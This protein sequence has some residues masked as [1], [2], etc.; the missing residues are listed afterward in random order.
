[1]RRSVALREARR[2]GVPPIRYDDDLPVSAKRDEIASAIRDHQVVIICGE[3]GSGKS[4]QLPKICLELGRGIDGLI[5]HTQPRRI[6]ARSVAARIAEELGSPLGR[7]VGFK[8]RFAEAL[9]P[10][11]YIKLMT[12]GILLAETQGDAFLDQ[13]DTII[14]DEAHE[15]SLNIDFLI[16]YLKRLLPKRRDLKLIITSA[17]IDAARFS[18]HFATPR[19]PGAGGRGFRADVS[20]RSPLAAAAG[21]RR[22]RRARLAAGR[23]G[24]RRGSRGHR[25]AA[26][27]SSSC[28]PSGT[29]TRRPRRSAAGRCPAIRPAGRRKSCRSTPGCRCGE[30]QRVFQPGPKRRIVIATNVAESSLTV[31]R[32]RYVIDP[33]TARISRYSPRSKTQRLPIEPVSRASADQ[34]KGRCGRIGPGVCVRLFSEE[35]YAAR[36]AY[37]PPEIQRT[38]LAAVIL[39]TKA[40]RLGPIERFPFLDPPKPEA[41]RDGYRTLVELGA[42]DAKGE[43]TEIGRQLSRL[44][45][46]PRFGRMILAAAEEGCLHEVLIIAAALAVQDPRERPLEKQEAADAC[47]ALRADEQSDFVGY[48]KLWDFYHK[49]KAELSRNQLRKACRQNFLSFN[50][51]REWLDVH[52]ELMEL[53][54]AGRARPGE[55]QREGRRTEA[56]RHA[57]I[58]RAHAPRLRRPTASSKAAPIAGNTTTSTAPSSRACSPAWPS[59]ATA[60]ST[61]WP[62]AARPTSGPAPACSSR[63]PSGWWRPRWSRRRGATCGPAGRSIP[64]GS[65]GSPGT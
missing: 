63:S 58:P 55:R 61:A 16:G 21:R 47:H 6:A 26:T 27:S 48:L 44:P 13:Y 51:M 7:D 49:L 20:G 29:S 56:R 62:A 14:L 59:A 53:V 35:D 5:G 60:T 18:A 10:Q 8:V 15:R 64:A 46:D 39:Q 25:S 36:D 23:A 22:R 65:S 38:N 2:R 31:P 52:R 43:L 54:R 50:R 12:D 11:T 45:I 30:Q 28:R 4:T 19:R 34:R 32:I 42:L 37:T 24:G 40:L 57:N 17:T 3:T 41:V 9:S 33:G 1:M